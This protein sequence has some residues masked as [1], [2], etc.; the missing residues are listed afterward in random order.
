MGDT[1]KAV[2]QLKNNKTRDPYGIYNETFKDCAE[3]N[4]IMR[5]LTKLYNG[6]KDKI[7]VPE[8]LT[9]G[10][11]TSIYKNKGSRTNLE[12]DRG[13]FILPTTKKILDTLL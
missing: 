7:H 9:H 5:A 11:I 12:N 1:I 4:D 13:I 6:V 2:K 10:N 3:E 8:F